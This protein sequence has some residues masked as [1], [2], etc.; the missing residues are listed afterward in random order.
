MRGK[1]QNLSKTEKKT[2]EEDRDRFWETRFAQI[3]RRGPQTRSKG[4]IRENGEKP[5]PGLDGTGG[6]KEVGME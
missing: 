5:T 2:E 3:N 6:Y 1:V 4:L